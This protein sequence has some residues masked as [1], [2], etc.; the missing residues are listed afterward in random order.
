MIPVAERVEKSLQI[1]HGD[2][3]VAVMGCEVNGPGEAREADVGIAYGHGGVGLLFKKGKVVKRLP[4]AELE[5]ALVQEAQ[6]IATGRGRETVDDEMPQAPAITA[7]ASLHPRAA[8]VLAH[9]QF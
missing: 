7:A 5:G 6:E 2:V 9:T 4:V 3:H 1:L 8:E